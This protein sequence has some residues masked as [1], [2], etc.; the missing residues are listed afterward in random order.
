M[1]CLVKETVLDG[2]DNSPVP[3]KIDNNHLEIR[4]HLSEKMLDKLV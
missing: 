2:K 4:D 3:V 1:L